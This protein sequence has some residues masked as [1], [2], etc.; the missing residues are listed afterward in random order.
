MKGGELRMHIRE[1]RAKAVELGLVPGAAKK[2]DLI[3]RIQVAEG[4][5]P[6]YGTSK[7]TC[8]QTDCCFRVDCLKLV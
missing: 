2:T 4:Y 1:V 8:V 5:S 6:C 7:G 3:R